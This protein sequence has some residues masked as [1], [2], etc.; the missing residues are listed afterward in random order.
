MVIGVSAGG[1]TALGT[2]LPQ[3]P[4]DFS[5]AVI[6]ALHLHPRSDLFHVD[7]FAKLCALPVYEAEEKEEVRPGAI[8][9]AAPNYH[10]LIEQD[11]TFSLSVDQRVRYARPSIDVL[12]ETAARA[13]GCKLIGVILTGANNDGASG[14]A[15]IKKAGGLTIVQNPETAEVASMP[16]AAIAACAVDFILDLPD[17]VKLLCAGLGHKTSLPGV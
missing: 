13:Y 5:P 8:Y 2:I 15:M 6:V 7:H 10:L 11:K 1:M 16:K 4:A 17:I 3:L 9:F 14:L 12:F